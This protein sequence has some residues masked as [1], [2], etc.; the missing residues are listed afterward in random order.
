MLSETKAMQKLEEYAAIFNDAV[1][2][3]DYGVA[4]NMYCMAH[5]VAVFMEMG[6]QCLKK[7]FGDWDSDDGTE[8]N[9]ALDNGLF[10][11]ADV[12]K[13][14]LECCIRRNQAYEDMALRRAGKPDLQRYYSEYEYCARCQERKKRAAR[15]WSDSMLD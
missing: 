9:T 1:Y 7:L 3:K 8:T 12:S 6:D 11:R 15:N 14:N 4:H 5:T 2:R 13:V 10:K